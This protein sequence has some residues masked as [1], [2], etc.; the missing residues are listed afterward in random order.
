[1]SVRS[2]ASISLEPS[3][4]GG[5]WLFWDPVE[6]SI[7]RAAALGFHAVELFAGAYD[8]DLRRSVARALEATGLSLSCVGTGGGKMFH[9]LTLTDPDAA[10][11]RRAIDYA[12]SVI[13][14][15]AAFGA[16]ATIGSMQG[17]VGAGGDR[18]PSVHWLAEGLE[19]LAE[20]AA[21]RGV[22]LQYEPLNRYETDLFNRQA[23]AAEVLRGL[24]TENVRLLADLFHMNIEESSPAEAIV[25][26]GEY[27]GYLHFVDSNRCA[28]G[29]GHI[30]MA[31][32]VAALH[33]IGFDGYA[34]A[35]AKAWPDSDTAARQ[36]R[37]AFRRCFET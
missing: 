15:G 35:E 27:I 12:A 1:M 5:P 33:K 25:D 34:A 19:F 21:S 28:V 16:P 36:T 3:V 18:E 14:F 20:H 23:D 11:R 9:G 13:D 37:A 6:V 17:A 31:P 10:V 7:P 2:S 26:A 24:E 22:T 4:A 29:M 30:D 32:I 8:E